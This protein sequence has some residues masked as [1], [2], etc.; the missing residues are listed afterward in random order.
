MCWCLNI[1]L[2]GLVVYIIDVKGY[3]WLQLDGA[4]ST[5]NGRAL[6]VLAIVY[7]WAWTILNEGKNEPISL[8]DWL[9]IRSTSKV[10]LEFIM[11]Y[12][13]LVNVGVKQDSY[14]INNPFY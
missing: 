5:T 8:L 7:F 14:L 12:L 13:D 4:K 11:I 1:I 2:L 10:L 3:W 6:G 9:K